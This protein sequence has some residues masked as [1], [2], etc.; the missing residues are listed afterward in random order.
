MQQNPKL[1]VDTFSEVS[2]L[3]EPYTDDVFWNFAEHTVVPGAVYVIGREQLNHNINK[4]QQLIENNI[5]HIVFSNPAEGSET[6]R[7]H[8][9]R[10]GFDKYATSGRMLLIG[11][12]NMD[13]SWNYLCY[14]SFLPKILDYEENIT[15]QKE[16]IELYQKV[17]KPYKF[18]FLNGRIRPHRKY[19]IEQF[20][21]SGLL[22]NSLWSCL[23][24]GLAG[25]RSI[26]LKHNGTNL[27]LNPGIIQYLPKEYEYPA[28]RSNINLSNQAFVKYRLFNNDWGEI[29]IQPRAYVDTYFSLVTE[30]VF[31]YPYSFRTEKIWK[32][33][34]MAHPWIAVANAGY[35]QDLKNLGFQTF[36]HVIDESFDLI[37]NNQDRIERIAQVVEDLCQQDL[38]SFLAECYNI[39]IYN[40]EHLAY[41][42]T[43][44]R[45]DF[46]ER[47]FQFMRKHQW[48]T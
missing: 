40:Q 24:T 42:R 4:I 20:Q 17:D 10:V 35:Y 48:M 31:E 8:V 21:L 26:Q 34:A 11:G 44:V 15:A 22:N 37:E 29:Y 2:D 28:Y 38:A 32:P 23:D 47:F 30:T 7:H 5:A 12:G 19:L 41:M 1:I 33:I 18:L 3:L 43:K 9:T 46:P 25:S 14:D 13:P 27:L 16:G 39:C 6:L 36:S 45:Q